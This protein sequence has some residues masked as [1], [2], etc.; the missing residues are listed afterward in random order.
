M[1][2]KKLNCLFI[3]ICVLLNSTTVFAT[4]TD[5]P[6]IEKT[7]I[8][9]GYLENYGIINTPFVRGFEGLGYEYLEEIEKYT[10]YNFDFISTEWAEGFEMLER[11]EID[12]FGIASMNEE[13]KERVEFV[14]TPIC[15]ENACIYAPIDTELYY[16][17][18]KGLNGLTIGMTQGAVYREALEKYIANNNIDLK[19]KF[20][21]NTDFEEYIE[22]GEIDIYLAGSLLIKDDMKIIDELYNEPLY[23]ISTKGNKKLCNNIEQAIKSIEKTN[24]YFEELLWSKYYKDNQKANK[25]ITSEEKTALSKKSSYRVGYHSDLLPISYKSKQG[26]PKGYA[27]DVMNILAEKLNINVEYVPLYDENNN[28]SNDVDFNLNPITDEDVKHDRFSEPYNIQNLLVVMD[29]NISKRDVKN[30]LTQDYTTLK[31]EDILISYPLA[32]IHKAYSSSERRKINQSEDIDCTIILEGT[33]S[34]VLDVK[35]K[36]I[37]V[38]DVSIPMGIIVN[39]NLSNDV[40]TALNKAI[41]TL[42]SNVV[43]EIIL[44]NVLSSK[45]E[46]TIKDVLVKYQYY[47][48]ALVLIIVAIIIFIQRMLSKKAKL[49]MGNEISIQ[50]TLNNCVESLYNSNTITQSFENMLEHTRKYYNADSAYYFE[51]VDATTLSNK[52]EVVKQKSPRQND[53]LKS[54]PISFIQS[55]FDYLKSNNKSCIDIMQCKDIIDNELIKMLEKGNI[56]VIIISPIEDTNGNL[57]GFIGV[58][59]PAQNKDKEDLIKL[60]SRFVLGFN[61]QKE[62]QKLEEENVLREEKSRLKVLEYCSKELQNVN[63]I[64]TKIVNILNLLRKHYMSDYAVIIEFSEDKR[65]YSVKYESRDENISSKFNESQ[66]RPIKVIE[67]IEKAIE[68]EQMVYATYSINDIEM[69]TEESKIMEYYKVKNLLFSPLYNVNNNLNGFIALNNPIITSRSTSLLP[70]VAKF[71]SDFGSKISMQFDF[72]NKI[73]REPLTGLMN[74][75]ATQDAIN[76]LLENDNK[77]V[78]FMIDLDRFKQLNDTLG[79]SMGDTALIILSAEIKKTFRNSDIV[80]RIGGDEFMVFCANPISDKMVYEKANIIC[81][82]CN[83]IFE[84]DGLTAEITTS[85][86]IYRVEDKTNFQEVYEKVDKALYIAKERGKNQFYFAEEE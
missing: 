82:K 43:D 29:K 7:K 53:E 66:N 81:K 26:E 58:D 62:L 15:Y 1:Q 25:Y 44:E 11:G 76:C 34:F 4:Q 38:S 20:T 77:G 19:I 51:K 85:I 84:K 55:L 45:P 21:E 50:K 63:D 33:E 83:R 75:I 78:I 86:G 24:P 68:K 9:V 10:N 36:N 35:N 61:N 23:F 57:I 39:N 67:K 46:P 65:T 18:P 14:E 49:V 72:N 48:M 30:I 80:G 31:I 79:H 16:N 54:F 74:K 27:I 2:L 6:N 22:K 56:S 59:N 64:E 73:S 28:N 52:Y 8:K 17:D 12:L 69:S 40:F 37:Q 70:T 60:L 47:I 32:K 41:L 5:S 3:I 13:R 71:I 42:N